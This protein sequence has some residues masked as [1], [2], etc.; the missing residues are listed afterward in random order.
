MVVLLGGPCRQEAWHRAQ[1]GGFA[2]ALGGGGRRRTAATRA[3][4]VGVAPPKRAER[5]ESLGWLSVPQRRHG[6]AAGARALVASAPPKS[7]F[8]PA[9]PG[10]RRLYLERSS[11]SRRDAGGGFAFGGGRRRPLVGAVRPRQSAGACRGGPAAAASRRRVARPRA[12]ADGSC[13]SDGARLGPRPTLS[14]AAVAGGRRARRRRRGGCGE[15]AVAAIRPRVAA[16]APR[17]PRLLRW[18]RRRC[19]AGR[20]RA[21]CGARR[22]RALAPSPPAAWCR[23]ARGEHLRLHRRLRSL[24]A[25]SAAASSAA[26]RRPPGPSA[27]VVAPPPRRGAARAITSCR[28]AGCSSRCAAGRSCKWSVASITAPPLRDRRRRRR[29]LRLRCV[30]R[31]LLLCL[32][33]VEPVSVRATDAGCAPK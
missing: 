24:P 16:A 21:R 9:P 17:L 5:G 11:A 14:A 8:P 22:G 20:V 19:G 15:P 29:L 1:V 18:R 26:P 4:A 32:R 28:F 2:R 30:G 10:R 13:A 6:A 23:R 33:R 3:P 25:A 27:A 31:R 7:S 12:A